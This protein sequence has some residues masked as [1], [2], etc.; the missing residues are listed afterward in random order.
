[1]VVEREGEEGKL[2]KYLTSERGGRERELEREK[3]T[4]DLNR[5][6]VG[7]IKLNLIIL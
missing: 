5:I 6:E 3:E 4:A 1:M 7:R 2:G